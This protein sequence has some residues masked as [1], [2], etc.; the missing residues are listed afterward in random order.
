ME[1][2]LQESAPD[3]GRDGWVYPR[4]SA[5]I[6]GGFLPQFRF[7]ACIK[8]GGDLALDDGDWICLQCG[9]YYYVGLYRP[10]E[11][12]R[13]PGGWPPPAA[14]GIWDG[15]WAA[16]GFFGRDAAAAIVLGPRTAAA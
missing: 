2:R 12:S 3:A 1:W 15:N 10:S 7:K 16:G 13:Y 14:K 5:R 9:T 11:R 6:I 8:C 4:M